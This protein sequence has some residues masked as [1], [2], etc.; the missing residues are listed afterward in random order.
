M[1]KTHLALP[2]RPR[3]FGLLLAITVSFIGGILVAPAVTFPSA[4]SAMHVFQ[5]EDLTGAWAGDDGGTYYVRQID[6]VVWWI[7]LDATD[8]GAFSNVFHGTRQGEFITGRW[9]D[10]PRGGAMSSGALVIQVVHG[11]K[12]LELRKRRGT[13]GFGGAT[14]SRTAV[15]P[16]PKVSQQ[17]AVE[18]KRRILDDG[19]VEI[20]MPDGTVRLYHPNGGWTTIHPDGRREGVSPMQI[21]VAAP[22]LSLLSASG[23]KPWLEAHN[24]NLRS[25]IEGLLPQA[26]RD[27]SMRSLANAERDKS[28]YQ[29]I[30]FR[31]GAISKLRR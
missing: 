24:R 1:N 11:P 4:A 16:L 13:G 9:A 12:G 10:V 8:G 7:G 21:Q 27:S 19:T 18:T 15:S 14:W 17:P 5:E 2:R 31:T 3:S 6:N 22:P 20:H 29:Q 25:I 23:L 26:E 28:L 30:E